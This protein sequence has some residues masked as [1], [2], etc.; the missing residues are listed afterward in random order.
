M[1][2][3]K[4]SVSYPGGFSRKMSV[5]ISI[6]GGWRLVT[7]EL[8]KENG[9]VI[10]PYGEKARGSLIYTESGRYSAQL[11]RSDRPRFAIGDQMLGTPGE[12]E[13]NY[14]GSISYFGTYEIHV[15]NRF[16]IH[17]VESS[18]FPIMEG[19]YPKPFFEL[20]ED[21]LQLTTPPIKLDGG[22]A[23]GLLLW[24]RIK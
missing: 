20:S 4:S 5:A 11:M 17:P 7:F 3:K 2:C 9:N 10:H 24:E 21:S 12:I 16:V 13:A 18:I 23:V 6:V 22:M 14:K 1:R 8:R 15:E 19:T